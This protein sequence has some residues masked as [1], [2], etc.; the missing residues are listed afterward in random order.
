[1]SIWS[2]WQNHAQFNTSDLTR[3]GHRKRS[4]KPKRLRKG[5]SKVFNTATN[6]IEYI[7][8]TKLKKNCSAPKSICIICQVNNTE[9]NNKHCK[10][11]SDKV[12]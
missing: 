12:K 11:C 8:V 5:Y 2:K 7:R 6:T 9:V 3:G 1:M 10:E 4:N